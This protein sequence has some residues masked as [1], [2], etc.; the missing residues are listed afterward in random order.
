ISPG[1]PKEKIASYLNSLQ[2]K[3]ASLTPLTWY[4]L[5]DGISVLSIPL[6]NDDSCLLID[7]PQA[8]IV[9]LNDSKPTQAQLKKLRGY[10]NEAVN[11]KIIVLSS[12]SPASIVNSFRKNS[13]YVSIKDKNDYIVYINQLVSTLQA[14]YFI[15]FASQVIFY[16]P[17]S[18]WANQY[19]VTYDDMEKGWTAPKTKLLHPYSCIDLNTF[20]VTYVAPENYNHNSADIKEKVSNY[21]ESVASVTLDEAD[22]KALEKKLRHHRF[23]L[24]PLFP[25]GIGFHIDNQDYYFNTWKGRLTRGKQNSSFALQVPAQ[26]MKD[27]VTYGHFGDLGITMFTL[28]I[29]NRSN[30]PKLIYIFF[31]L[32]TL[33]DYGHTVSF[34]NFYNW[35]KSAFKN[36]NWNI[37][38]MTAPKPVLV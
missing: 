35:I 31:I 10:M 34:K 27:A 32:L 9:N 15:P 7:T 22:E 33:H 12:Y 21:L 18:A 23:I 5:D 6:Y 4:N 20:D 3:S 37:P 8:F 29:L 14:D 30:N 17:D 38:P 24:A 13:E 1:L 25:R 2:F 26:A 28:V 11:K 16:R 19:K 36:Y